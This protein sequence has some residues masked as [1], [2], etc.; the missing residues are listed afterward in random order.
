MC[1]VT[2]IQYKCDC[3]YYKIGLCSDM[4]EAAALRK[5]LSKVRFQ[6][7]RLSCEKRSRE[8]FEPQT[9]ECRTCIAAKGEKDAATTSMND[10]GEVPITRSEGQASRTILV[11]NMPVQT[12]NG[13]Q[14]VLIQRW[15]RT[16]G[17]V[18][19]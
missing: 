17:F 12:G 4:E 8:E 11:D 1:V 5:T 2:Q 15:L 10:S 14:G 16:Q 19:G 3:K 7:L 18:R 6:E 9:V 13:P